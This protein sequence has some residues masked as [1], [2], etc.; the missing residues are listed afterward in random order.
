MRPWILLALALVS[1]QAV[2]DV[3]PTARTVAW[4]ADGAT[5]A[6]SAGRAEEEDLFATD[7]ASGGTRR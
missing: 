4:S 5:I 7:V 3:P 6:W 1:R 2:A